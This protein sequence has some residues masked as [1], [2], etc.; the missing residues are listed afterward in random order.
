[1]SELKVALEKQTHGFIVSQWEN[2][3]ETF[4]KSIERPCKSITISDWTY[5][6]D[7]AFQF[8][9]QDEALDFC[10]LLEEVDERTGEA[11]Q[12]FYTTSPFEEYKRALAY[13]AL[14]WYRKLIRFICED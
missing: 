3:E 12:P 13:E 8:D 1:M 10:S 4:L 9:T 14:P 11:I 5:D 6:L 7:E 2:G